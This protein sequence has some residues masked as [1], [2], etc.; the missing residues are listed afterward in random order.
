MEWIGGD[1][2]IDKYWDYTFRVEYKFQNGKLA[3]QRF[4]KITATSAIEAW[5]IMLN[6]PIFKPIEIT[7]YYEHD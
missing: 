2:D 4:V 6:H 1:Y 3:I 5:V 7:R